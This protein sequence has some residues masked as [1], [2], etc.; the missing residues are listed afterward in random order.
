[1]KLINPSVH[2]VDESDP[3]KKIERVGRTCY[4]SEDMI[5]EDS[6][7]KFYKGLVKRNHTAMLEHVTFVFQVD[8]STFLHL[9]GNRYL[10]YTHNLEENRYLVSGNMRAINE[11]GK[12]ILFKALHD[13]DPELVYVTSDIPC[14]DC[15]IACES[16]KA[17]NIYNLP[18]L[19]KEEFM[20]H[21]YFSFRFICDR[22]V[23][24]EI[25]RH[26]PASYAQESTRYCN[27]TKDKFGGEI[28]F[29]K[30]ANW[31]SF[32]DHV[33]LRYTV[34]WEACEDE[35]ARLISYG[36]TPQQARAVLPNALKTEIVMTTNAKEYEHFFDLR[37][38]GTTG[39]P[40]PDMKVVADMALALYESDK[41]YILG[42]E[43]F[44]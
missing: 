6:A 2:L 15:E 3:F 28:T 1:M 30:P 27:Y 7:R 39:S 14:V 5:T 37:S 42:D 20:A 34:A 16:I 19:T 40:H 12:R 8:S 29:I 31:G 21:A 41:F 44:K 32:P 38:R 24:H 36:Q 35:Y 22:G 10:H 23:T 17:V 13:I 18:N 43:T 4:K 9:L 11:S 25:V 26:R 33:K